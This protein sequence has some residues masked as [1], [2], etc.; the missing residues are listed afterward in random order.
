VMQIASEIGF[1]N[2][3]YFSTRFIQHFGIS[4]SEVFQSVI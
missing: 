2:E 4:P 1:K 3:K